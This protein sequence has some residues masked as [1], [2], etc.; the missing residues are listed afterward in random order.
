MEHTPIL[1]AR[2][3]TLFGR[4]G[5][6]TLTNPQAQ[7]ERCSAPDALWVVLPDHFTGTDER[8]CSLK[9]LEREQTQCV[10]HNDCNAVLA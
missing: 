3:L 5:C 9:L 7:A 10:A 6:G 4:V 8:R 2:L 1:L